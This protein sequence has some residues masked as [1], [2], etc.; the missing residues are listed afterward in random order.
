MNARLAR[1]LFLTM[2][3]PGVAG[4]RE[5]RLDDAAIEAVRTTPT[6]PEHGPS[7]IRYNALC[8]HCHGVRALGTEQGPPLVDRVYAPG[9]HADAAFHLAVREG[10]RAHHF[11]FGDMPVVYGLTADELQGVIDYIRW[12][13]RTAG[14]T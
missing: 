8:S 12:L 10:V 3:L 7:E 1:W 13:Q 2:L 11:R 6:P 4:C 5:H 9:H 14:I